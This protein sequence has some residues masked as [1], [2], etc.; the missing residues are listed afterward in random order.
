MRILDRY[1][2]RMFVKSFV[3]C[4]F[5]LTGLYI[6][7]D[8]FGNLDEFIKNGE[9]AGGLLQL[10]TD[11]YAVRSLAF[12]D[13][14]SPLL[15]LL[16]SIFT[17]TLMQ[18]YNEMTAL[19][20]AGIS[21]PRIVS[22]L[23]AAVIC[24]SILATGNREFVIPTLRD[25]LAHTPQDLWGEHG[26]PLRPRYDNA[27]GILLQGKRTFSAEQ[28]IEQPKFRLPPRHASFGKQLVA[29][30]AEYRT[31][32]GDRPGGYL[33]SGVTQP[34]EIHAIP[35]LSEGGRPIVLTQADTQW[36]QP[37]ECFVAS[38][39][40]FEQLSADRNWRQFASTYELI[41]GLQNPSL[42]HGANVRVTI[43]ARFVQPFL[44]ISLIF[45][46]LPLVLAKNG[47]NLFL[48]VALCMGVMISRDLLVL[49]CHSLGN[50]YLISPTFAAWCP[51]IVTVPVAIFLSEGLRR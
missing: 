38:E 14:V 43:H 49:C 3:V 42:D 29:E 5:S 10:V 19:L 44:D 12:F 51:L 2:L 48:G 6:V 34:L 28:R 40:D 46:G 9:R 18:R 25:K 13:R 47:R 15:A 27:T 21:V 32:T 36:L 22:P 31:R 33:L 50:S 39:V 26:R 7:I 20:A 1:L 11:Y 30:S 16:G 17:V 8:C 23:I 24:I 35:S 4:F 37:D 41:S 45:I